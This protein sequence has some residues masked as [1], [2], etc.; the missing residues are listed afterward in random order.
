MKLDES[1][2]PPTHHSCVS[3]RAANAARLMQATNQSGGFSSCG[4]QS[5]NRAE[6]RARLVAKDRRLSAVS[7][8]RSFMNRFAFHK[9]S[10]LLIRDNARFG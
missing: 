1:S 6:R 4:A 7:S 8:S 9:R 3:V 2:K 5:R 10:I